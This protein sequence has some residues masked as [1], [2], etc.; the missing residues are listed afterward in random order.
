MNNKFKNEIK[1]AI[2]EHNESA[3][4]KTFEKIYHQ[5]CNLVRYVSFKI[6]RRNDIADD[7]TQEVFIRF[8]NNLQS[9]QFSNIKYWLVTVAKNLS[10]N[11]IKAK[12]SQVIQNNEDIIN[13]EATT[14]NIKEMINQIKQTL[15][16]EEVDIIIMHLIFNY[17]FREIAAEKGISANAVYGKYRRAVKKFKK[18]NC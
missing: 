1:R 13:K 14:G 5:Y 18:I 17:T 7:I 9:T 2:N 12:D 15:S 8:F 11:Y 6:V 4:E 10:L 16:E 3:L